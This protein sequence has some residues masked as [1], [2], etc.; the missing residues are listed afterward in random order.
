[1]GSS[2]EGIC[3][4][5]AKVNSLRSAIA[6]GNEDVAI[7][8]GTGRDGQLYWG[9]SGQSEILFTLAGRGQHACA[10]VMGNGG[11]LG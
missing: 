1:V 11:E 10:G 7:G 2:Y 5:G 6:H 3:V 4:G 9:G 8:A